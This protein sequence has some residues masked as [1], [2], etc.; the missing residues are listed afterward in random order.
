MSS[1]KYTKLDKVG[2]GTYGVVYKA[3]DK[4]SGQL[5]ALKRMRLE[6]EDEGIPCSALREILLLKELK[7][8]N[9]VSLIDVAHSEKKLTLV[10]EFM[11]QDLK[12][13]LDSH[14]GDIA[15]C[16]VGSF[17]KQLVESIAYCH[18]RSVLHRDLKPQNLLIGRD[19][20]L[21]LA[22]FGLGRSFGIPVKKYTHEVVTLWYRSPDVLLG[23]I[24]YGT[25]VDMWS[26][27]CIFAEMASGKP[28]FAGKNEHE[29]LVKVFRFLGEPSQQM[30]T[31]PKSAS[32]LGHADFQK[33]WSPEFG[34]VLQKKC[35]KMKL[36]E[37]GCDLLLQY[38]APDPGKRIGAEKSLSHP[39]FARAGAAGGR[40]RVG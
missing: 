31:F 37:D 12:M 14:S 34:D 21:K 1:T 23:S 39:Y 18:S 17:Q 20:T 11:D 28:L 6:V 30:R 5:V 10:F 33:A 22:D 29:Q 15:A 35:Y 25:G 4:V 40:G 16:D 26:I 3:K 7:H 19:K 32:M 36:N 24:N 8:P 13:Y 27:G 38:L 9:I 2:E